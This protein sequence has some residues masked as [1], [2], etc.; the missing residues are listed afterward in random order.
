M[1]RK[2]FTGDESHAPDEKID[3]ATLENIFNGG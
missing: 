2:S 3:I 1:P